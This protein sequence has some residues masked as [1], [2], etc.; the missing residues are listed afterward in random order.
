M[1]VVLEIDDGLYQHC[2]AIGKALYGSPKAAMVT[3]MRNGVEDW[4][5]SIPL[6]AAAASHMAPGLRKVW[7]SINARRVEKEL[8]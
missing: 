6:S 1:K 2:V 4:H 3:L 8:K 7:T 5:R